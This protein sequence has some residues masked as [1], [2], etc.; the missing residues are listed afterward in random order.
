MQFTDHF[1]DG[2]DVIPLKKRGTT[3]KIIHGRGLVLGPQKWISYL[4]IDLESKCLKQ[5]YILAHVILDFAE[6]LRNVRNLL[7]LLIKMSYA[8]YPQEILLNEMKSH[9][10]LSTQVEMFMQVLVQVR[11]VCKLIIFI[12]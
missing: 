6:N 10:R 12:H 11:S 2:P 1:K 5:Q 8:C 3:N 4:L 7:T 9:P